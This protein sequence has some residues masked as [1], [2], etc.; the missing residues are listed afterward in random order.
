MT[1]HTN[2]GDKELL[3][4]LASTP[5]FASRQLKAVQSVR[6]Y[7]RRASNVTLICAEFRDEVQHF[8]AKVGESDKK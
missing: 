6:H 5:Y 7:H 3:M 2:I 8:L 1:D 4:L